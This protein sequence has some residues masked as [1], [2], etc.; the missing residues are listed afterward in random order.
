MPGEDDLPES[1]KPFSTR[2]A[3]DVRATR[4]HEDVKDF[5]DYLVELKR[6]KLRGGAERLSALLAGMCRDAVDWAWHSGRRRRGVVLT[7]AAVALAL[8]L[9]GFG[10]WAIVDD[11]G[12]AEVSPDPAAAGGPDTGASETGP[13]PE[14]GPTLAYSAGSRVYLVGED[15]RRKNSSP[16]TPSGRSPT[17]RPTGRTSPS[18]RAATSGRPTSTASTRCR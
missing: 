7:T 5:V 4:W 1:L 2:N 17:G 18:A 8:V 14:P 15:G 11:P 10:I 13:T 6:K 3:V 9:G 16:G 12:T